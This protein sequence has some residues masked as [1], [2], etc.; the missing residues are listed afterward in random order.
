M[1]FDKDQLLVFLPTL[2]PDNTKPKMYDQIRDKYVKENVW[3]L[4][5]KLYTKLKSIELCGIIGCNE[6]VLE[7]LKT[8]LQEA[9][10]LESKLTKAWDRWRGI[11]KDT[12]EYKFTEVVL[13]YHS[14][15]LSRIKINTGTKL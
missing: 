7:P 2:L 8:E 10:S 15:A 12:P 6:V 14:E 5:Y 9:L 11:V 1:S 3:E 13:G 4:Q